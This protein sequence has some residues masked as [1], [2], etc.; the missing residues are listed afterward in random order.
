MSLKKIISVKGIMVAAAALLLF[1]CKPEPVA[2]TG[3]LLDQVEC[4]LGVGSTVTLT[5]TVLPADAT[6]KKIEWSVAPKGIVEISAKENVCT[7]KA[8]KAGDVTVTAKTEEGGKTATCK[9]TAKPVSV[10]G[11]T[12]DPPTLKLP[13]GT[14]GTVT[15]A[16][17]PENATNKTVTWTAEP[18]DAVELTDN[19]NGSCTV[20]ALTK[21]TVT[22]TAKT[23][24]GEKTAACEVECTVSVTGIALDQET[25]TIEFEKTVT[26]TATVTP[27]EASD[28]TVN[29]TAE[30]ADAVELTDNGD[31]TCVV[32]GLKVGDAVVKA[33]TADG[34]YED[35]CTVKVTPVAVKGITLSPAT[36]ELTLGGSTNITVTFDPVNASDKEV[37]WSFTPEETHLTV[38]K[39]EDGTYAIAADK[40]CQETTFTVTATTN[41]GGKTA[42]CQVTTKRVPVTGVSLNRRTLTVTLGEEAQTLTATVKPGNATDKTVTWKA[43]PEAAVEL[44]DNGD[45][46]CSVKAKEGI[47]KI[48]TVTVTATTQ[49]GGHTATCTVT[50]K[51]VLVTAIYTWDNPDAIVGGTF[52][53]KPVIYP[54]NATNKK[55]EWTATVEG[56]PSEHITL[57]PSED[58]TACTVTIAK[59]FGKTPKEI[60]FKAAATDGSEQSGTYTVTPTWEPVEEILLNKPTLALQTGDGVILTATVLPENASDKTVTW[61]IDGDGSVATMTDNGDGTCTVTAVG[62]GTAT[63]TVTGNDDPGKTA[64]CQISVDLL[65]NTAFIEAVGDKC[66]WTK[67]GDGTVLLTPENLAVMAAVT[68]LDLSN[69]GLTDLGGIEYFTGLTK[70]NISR[71]NLTSLDVSQNTN[72]TELDCRYNKLT[73]LDVSLLTAL[74]SLS[75]N[76]NELTELDVSALTALTVLYCGQNNLSKLD[77]SKNT[78]LIELSCDDN[79]FLSELNLS[80][81]TKLEKLDCYRCDLSSLNLSANTKLTSLNVGSQALT[82]DLSSNTEL[83]SL[84][85]R[86]CS[87]TEL[88]LSKQTKLESLICNNNQLTTLNLSANTALKELVCYNNTLTE[89]DL[90]ANTALKRLE[91]SSSK[92]TSLNLSGV[93]ALEVLN[94]ENSSLTTLDLSTNTALRDLNCSKNNLTALDVSNNTNLSQLRCYQ[95]KLTTLDITDTD[96]ENG[97]LSCGQQLDS[98]G[99]QTQ[100]L[101]LTLTSA[102]KSQWD[103]NWSRDGFNTNV[104]PTVK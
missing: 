104:K 81:N 20:K 79:G 53:L 63:V 42:T 93:V 44:T 60:T 32:K 19:K 82:F 48:E 68:E 30:P 39:N 101:T 65:G 13:L 69:K 18:A 67:E 90:S 95:N 78:E 98:D 52:T 86:Y 96:L 5:A 46:T 75:C 89:L 35:A 83:V 12:L 4:D 70:L 49:D 33:T 73:E 64:T 61:A 59:G 77:V 26:L 87:L 55:L 76:G 28:K 97:W 16:V 37:T 34:G 14:S 102:Q 11:I 43:D 88:D 56:N 99:N 45:G 72:L 17:L 38:T 62:A 51:P 74:T 10:T 94:C 58:G 15:A 47:T 91:C 36:Q 40:E 57:E 23:E 100:K 85:C 1:A 9:I 29:W 50:V 3:V 22:V 54:E 8:V 6:N 80:A 2:V 31:G 7:V 24:D 66:T 103:I 71:N 25:A 21:G 84:D 92:L 41:D 27:E